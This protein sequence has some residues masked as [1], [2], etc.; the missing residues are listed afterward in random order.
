MFLTT[1]KLQSRSPLKVHDP[2]RGRENGIENRPRLRFGS[3]KQLFDAEYNL[4]Q[5]TVASVLIAGMLLTSPANAAVVYRISSDDSDG[6]VLPDVSEVMTEGRPLQAVGLIYRSVIG[7]PTNPGTLGY[8]GFTTG[9]INREQYLEFGF[10]SAALLDLES[11]QIGFTPAFGPEMITLAVSIDGSNFQD[12]LT[13]D[14]PFQISGIYM[15]EVDLRGMSGRSVD[16]RFF[17]YQATRADGGLGLSPI[18]GIVPR[19]AIIVRGAVA[20]PEPWAAGVL[21]LLLHIY[22]FSGSVRAA[23]KS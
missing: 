14:T 7:T 9:E 22:F 10:G 2:M 6:V 17:G 23:R 11:V 21:P 19:T 8:Q 5:L 12:L 18:P 3:G 13:L 16:F 15:P 4:K 1:P 20:V